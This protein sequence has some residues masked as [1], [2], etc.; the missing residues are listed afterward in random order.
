MRPLELNP[1][2]TRID[3]IKGVGDKAVSLFRNLLSIKNYEIGDVYS[4][5]SSPSIGITTPKMI[6]ALYHLPSG[7]IDR[8]KTIR[9]SDAKSGDLVTTVVRVEEHQPSSKFS[10]PRLVRRLRL[11]AKLMYSVMDYRWRIRII[12]YQKKIW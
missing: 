9:L 7:I 12:L 3:T 1:L 2:F 4:E 6:D 5:N 8:T 11:V 10:K